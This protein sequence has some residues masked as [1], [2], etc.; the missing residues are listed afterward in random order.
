M[1]KLVA[2]AGGLLLG[3]V[4]SSSTASAYTST[5]ERYWREV[6]RS[7]PHTSG[8]VGKNEIVGLGWDTCAAVKA[9]ASM[10]DLASILREFDANT[11]VLASTAMASAMT[12]MCWEKR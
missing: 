4:A 1:K 2:V 3:L 9:G 10:S 7:H 6:Q 11:Q 12:Y 5:E 8:V